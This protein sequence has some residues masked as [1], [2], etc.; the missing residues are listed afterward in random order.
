MCGS[1]THSHI[2]H[3]TERTASTDVLF[4][5]SVDG[6]ALQRRQHEVIDAYLQKLECTHPSA[7]AAWG[8][9]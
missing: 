6:A 1:D 5:K 3:G 2:A 9:A 7:C 4:G 8:A